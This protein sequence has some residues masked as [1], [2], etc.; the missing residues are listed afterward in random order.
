[1]TTEKRA[2]NRVAA[3]GTLFASFQGT[4]RLTS[5]EAAYLA[6]L[7]DGEG[8]IVITRQRA[9]GPKLM[10]WNSNKPMIDWLVRHA[11]GTGYR[12]DRRGKQLCW[13]W[14]V[15]PSGIEPILIQLY[16][17]LV[18]KRRQARVM[19]MYLEH[20]RVY[21][22]SLG[23]PLTPEERAVRLRFADILSRLNTGGSKNGGRH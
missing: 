14:N 22:S 16:P 11:G 12:Q 17:Y 5:Q 20:R 23:H 15:S 18:A 21:G 2:A 8:S 19:L 9:T 1:M 13:L 10:L 3:G 6:G 4:P 7:I